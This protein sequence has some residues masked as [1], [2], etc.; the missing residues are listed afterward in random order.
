MK[1]TYRLIAF[2]VSAE[3]PKRDNTPISGYVLK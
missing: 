2:T 3:I 1:I